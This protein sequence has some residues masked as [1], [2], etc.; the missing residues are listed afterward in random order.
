MHGAESGVQFYSNNFSDPART[1]RKKIHGG[2]GAQGDGYEP[3][4]TSS[5]RSYS[6]VTDPVLVEPVLLIRRGYSSRNL[7][8]SLRMHGY[9]RP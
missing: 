9:M 1:A 2:S 4:C 7:V 8:L 3:G 6:L 5:L